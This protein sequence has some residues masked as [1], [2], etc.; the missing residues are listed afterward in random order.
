[1]S[2]F[3][4]VSTFCL[5]PYHHHHHHHLMH[6]E[7]HFSGE[8]NG[9]L[10]VTSYRCLIC[11]GDF[12]VDEGNLS[13]TDIPFMMVPQT[14]KETYRNSGVLENQQP[15]ACVSKLTPLNPKK[16]GVSP[17]ERTICLK[18]FGFFIHP[19]IWDNDLLRDFHGTELS[20]PRHPKGRFQQQ[21]GSVFHLL[22]KET[23]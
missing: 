21:L 15:F 12:F 19:I 23:Q 3:L 14:P 1:M 22:Q 17:K 7:F 18:L 8:K 16:W 4:E 6:H 10:Q 9:V 13:D 11:W 2:V 5:E 20:P